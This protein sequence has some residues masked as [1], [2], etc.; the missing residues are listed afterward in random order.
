LKLGDGDRYQFQSGETALMLAA[1]H[2]GPAAAGL[3][4]AAGANVHATDAF[5]SQS[6]L[7]KSAEEG[8]SE[9][10]AMLIGAGARLNQTNQYGATPLMLAVAND[11][12]DTVRVLLEAGADVSMIHPISSRSAL[13]TAYLVKNQ[14]IIDLL[15]SAGARKNLS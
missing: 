8:N 15:E 13:D 4:I 1:R 2:N 11:H 9:V 10:A 3:L 5:S 6:A 7:S 12:L 14:K